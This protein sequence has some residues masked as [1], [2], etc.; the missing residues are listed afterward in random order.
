MWRPRPCSRIQEEDER[1]DYE[2]ENDG[3]AD[4]SSE[5]TAA[6]ILAGLSGWKGGWQDGGT[7]SISTY[8]SI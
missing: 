1:D 3:R 8:L 7:I 2:A 6:L 4:A 5:M